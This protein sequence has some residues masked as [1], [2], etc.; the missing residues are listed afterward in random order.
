MVVQRR[1]KQKEM[2]MIMMNDDDGGDVGSLSSWESGKA[3]CFFI[4]HHILHTC[5][6]AYIYI[7]IERDGVM[8]TSLCKKIVLFF[9]FLAVDIE[10]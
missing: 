7:Y 3:N 2:V 10:F 8:V 5:I 9:R 1:D 4:S 6:Y